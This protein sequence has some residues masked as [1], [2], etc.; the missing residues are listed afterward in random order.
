V[1]L[2]KRIG[3]KKAKTA[4]SPAS[5]LSFYIASGSTVPSSNGQG[6]NMIH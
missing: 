5:S 3:I 2:A 1:R 4:V 6:E